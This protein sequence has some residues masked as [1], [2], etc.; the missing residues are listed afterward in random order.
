MNRQAPQRSEVEITYTP[1]PDHTPDG[2]LNV[3]AAVYRFAL[4]CHAKKQGR[5]TTSGPNDAEGFKNA[6][7]ATEIIPKRP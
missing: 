6:R 7:T 4:D 1:R 5:P 2:E 3:I